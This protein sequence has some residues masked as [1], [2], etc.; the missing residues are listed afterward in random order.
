MVENFKQKKY[1]YRIEIGFNY[2]EKNKIEVEE[3]DFEIEKIRDID[4]NIFLFRITE[5]NNIY[6]TK[7]YYQNFFENYIFNEIYIAVDSHFNIIDILNK[8]MISQKIELVK[9]EIIK[10]KYINENINRDFLE[11][12]KVL[13]DIELFPFIIEKYKFYNLFLN[14]INSSEIKNKLLIFDILKEGIPLEIKKYK[15]NNEY[16]AFG[17]LDCFQMSKQRF[18]NKIKK[19]FGMGANNIDIKYN[20]IVKLDYF[21]N[22]EA[23]DRMIQLFI[24]GDRIFYKRELLE[25]IKVE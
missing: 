13:E 14:E 1:K 7:K 4:E 22:T 17:E 25:E 19:E 9:K 23:A 21:K 15:K 2:K 11:I 3:C 12:E 18:G 20:N 5:K 10:L 6:F 16:I 8:E 24:E